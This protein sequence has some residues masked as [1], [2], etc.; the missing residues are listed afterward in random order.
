MNKISIYGASSVSTSLAR[1]FASNGIDVLYIDPIN[2]KLAKEIDDLNFGTEI[3]V[4]IGKMTPEN[5]K[6]LLAK[7]KTIATIEAI[8]ETIDLVINTKNGSEE[9]IVAMFQQI[10]A[11]IGEHTILATSSPAVAVTSIA[12]QT[13]RADRF[14]GLCFGVPAHGINLLELAKGFDT[15]SETIEIIKRFAAQINRNPLQVKDQVGFVFNRVAL[16]YINQAIKM[17]EQSDLG[18]LAIDEMMKIGMTQIVG[19]LQIADVRGLDNILAGLQSMHTATNDATYFPS[20]LLMQ[21]VAA[22]KTGKA[23]GE[24]FYKYVDGEDTKVAPYLLD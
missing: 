20:Q 24:G 22:G 21:L 19:P 7:I 17:L 6:N 10:E 14:V 4:K 15:S 3:L 2:D 1:L 9:D 23:V 12:T 11:N 18:V 5:R 8:D 13:K 16:V